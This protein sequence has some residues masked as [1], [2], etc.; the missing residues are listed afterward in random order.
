MPLGNLLFLHKVL[1]NVTIANGFGAIIF[2]DGA[3]SGAAVTDLTALFTT[4]QA[5]DD[6]VI[7]GTTPLL[8]E[9]LR[10]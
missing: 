9:P 1:V 2:A 8:L 7:G 10:L 3:G 4:S 6:V 5:I